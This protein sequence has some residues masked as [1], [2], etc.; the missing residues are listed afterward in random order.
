MILC[1]T[2]PSMRK[3]QTRTVCISIEEMPQR[4]EYILKSSTDWKKIIKKCETMI[5]TS[6]EYRQYIQFLKNE[7][8]YNK[9]AVLRGISSTPD[10]HYS[11]EVHHSPFTLYD[12]VQIIITKHLD[13]KGQINLFE[14]S[15]EV[16]QLHYEGKVGLIPLT[17]TV[18]ELVHNGKIFI[19]L[20]LIYQDYAEF[21]NEYEMWMSENTKDKIL[22]IANATEKCLGQIQDFGNVLQTEFVYLNVDGFEFPVVPEKWGHRV[23]LTEI[24]E[25]KDNISEVS[26]EILYRIGDEI[27]ENTFSSEQNIRLSDS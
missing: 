18:H 22:E 15:Q 2:S 9:C 3:R 24:V 17:A 19:P 11:I 13:Q 1:K 10:K 5:R 23:N 8:D 12:I 4:P 16:M 21:V 26:E 14:V 7:M 6:L 20:N 27:P 25:T